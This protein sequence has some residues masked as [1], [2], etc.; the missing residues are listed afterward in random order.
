MVYNSIYFLL[1][2]ENVYIIINTMPKAKK[3]EHVYNTQDNETLWVVRL[4]DGS[5]RYIKHSTIKRQKL[6]TSDTTWEPI[7]VGCVVKFGEHGKPFRY[8]Y[9]RGFADP[10]QE[11]PDFKTHDL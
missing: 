4:V 6:I 2:I 7:R 8:V 1:N 10:T 3:I 5:S 9:W 11:P